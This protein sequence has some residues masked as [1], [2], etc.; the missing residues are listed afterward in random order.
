MAQS[1]DL[2]L[3]L[4]EDLSLDPQHEKKKKKAKYC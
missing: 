2:L 3:Y 4:H 1:V